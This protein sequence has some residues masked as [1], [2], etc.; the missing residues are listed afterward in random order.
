[1]EANLNSSNVEKIAWNSEV[2][3]VYLLTG[4]IMRYLDVPSG[5]FEGIRTAMSAG[6]YLNRHVRGQFNCKRIDGNQDADAEFKK[7]LHHKDTTVGLWATD[8]PDLIPENIKKEFFF[9][10]EY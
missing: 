10:I 7:L 5:I 4:A 2:L 6:S 1:M 8:L 3:T 9:E